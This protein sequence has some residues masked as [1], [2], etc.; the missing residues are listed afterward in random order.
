MKEFQKDVRVIVCPNTEKKISR[1][2]Q[3]DAVLFP[4]KC[5]QAALSIKSYTGGMDT[6]AL[7]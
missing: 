7:H 4:T 5:K 6:Q 3:S 2:E 1:M